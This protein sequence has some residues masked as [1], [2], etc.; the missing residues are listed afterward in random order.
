MKHKE[1]KFEY[2]QTSHVGAY[3]IRPYKAIGWNADIKKPFFPIRKKGKYTGSQ[4]T[5]QPLP[6]SSGCRF[7]HV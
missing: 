5:Q 6:L 3:A 7:H 1:T 4:R 2:P